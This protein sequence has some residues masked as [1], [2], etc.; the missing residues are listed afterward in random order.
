MEKKKNSQSSSKWT[1]EILKLNLGVAT[2]FIL[3]SS[4]S[5]FFFWYLFYAIDFSSPAW[6]LG[7]HVL[8]IHPYPCFLVGFIVV[9]FVPRA[10]AV[11]LAHGETQSLMLSQEINS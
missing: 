10:A 8:I 7:G 9:Y 2:S 6:G 4:S 3:F 11:S 5:F 1:L